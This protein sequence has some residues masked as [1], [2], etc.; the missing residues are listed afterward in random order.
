MHA[1]FVDISDQYRGWRKDL[2]VKTA[3]DYQ[4]KLGKV[5]RMRVE[6]QKYD[7][8]I[9]LIHSGH[10]FNLQQLKD[11]ESPEKKEWVKK[12]LKD[13]TAM[14]I[15][16]K[17]AQ[18]KADQ[19]IDE[20]IWARME[21]EKVTEEWKEAVNGMNKNITAKIKYE[22]DPTANPNK[23]VTKIEEFDILDN[24]RQEDGS[25]CYACV[26]GRVCPVHGGQSFKRQAKFIQVK[27]KKGKKG[28]L[29]SDDDIKD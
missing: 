2:A 23:K 7:D 21:A 3:A 29:D 10:K 11:M 16:I 19:S 27:D 22:I 15:L 9:K 4:K 13:D 5:L 24:Y 20:N 6:R 17:Q 26:Q 25:M 14:H 18:F 12:V 28:I 1:G 8:F